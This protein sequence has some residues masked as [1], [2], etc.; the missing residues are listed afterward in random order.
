MSSPLLTV[1]FQEALERERFGPAARTV[2]PDL[3]LTALEQQF[4]VEW[5]VPQAHDS[6]DGALS[7]G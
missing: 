6:R 2:V 7:A 5:E 3:N 4:F 1:P